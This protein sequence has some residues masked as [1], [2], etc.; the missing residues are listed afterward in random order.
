MNEK[1]NSTVAVAG[2][3]AGAGAGTDAVAGAG[4]VGTP[5]SAAAVPEGGAPAGSQVSEKEKAARAKRMLVQSLLFEAALPIGGFYLLHGIGLNQ[6]LALTLSGLATVPWLVYGFVRRRRVEAMPLFSLLLIA[7]GTV[8][9]MVTGSPRLLLVRDSWVFGIIGL[10]VLGSLAT[11]RPFMLSMARTI[12]STKIGEAG[13]AAYVAQWHTD[14]RF[15]HHM[16]VLTAFWGAGFALDT[17]IRVVFA[18]TLP[19]N[20]VPLV[21]GL[22]WIAVLGVLIGGH[23]WYVTKNGLKV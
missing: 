12:V 11:Q 13:A 8:L 18:M 20:T 10:W 7:V 19:V 14:E 9:S 6:W 2:A 15:R 1:Q 23:Y 16:R 17:V 3:G 5:G 4:A 21:N 22:Q